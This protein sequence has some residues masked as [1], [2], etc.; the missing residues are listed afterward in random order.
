MQPCRV[1]IDIEL[2]L[3]KI[4]VQVI[5]NIFIVSPQRTLFL[6]VYPGEISGVETMQ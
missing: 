4:L 5:D 2:I 3:G 1:D 6:S